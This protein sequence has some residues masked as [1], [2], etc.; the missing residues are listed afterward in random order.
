[1]AKTAH[2]S[3]FQPP[4]GFFD[5]RGG[6]LSK[7]S[8][9]HRS[10]HVYEFQHLLGQEVL[11]SDSGC[12]KMLHWCLIEVRVVVYLYNASFLFYSFNVY[13]WSCTLKKN[14]FRLL[15]I[16]ILQKKLLK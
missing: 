13:G 10:V 2:F 3:L 5:A 14:N 6:G 15:I 12:L 8:L 9:G 16:I 4:D 1:M 11:W 7:D